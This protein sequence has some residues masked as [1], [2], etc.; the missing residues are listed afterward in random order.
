MNEIRVRER[1]MK[2]QNKIVPEIRLKFAMFSL[3]VCKIIA[4]EH[5]CFV[6]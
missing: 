4:V 5:D 3:Y 1:V 6:H 2:K